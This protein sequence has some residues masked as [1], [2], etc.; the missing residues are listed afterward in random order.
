MQLQFSR[1][2]SL[3]FYIEAF[4]LNIKKSKWLRVFFSPL[5]FLC[6][7]FYFLG[8]KAH[9]YMYKLH[10][11]Q[12]I[13]IPSYVIGIGN[14][15]VGGSGKTPFILKILKDLSQLNPAIIMRPYQSNNFGDEPQLVK[16]KF[17]NA[18]LFIGKSKSDVALGIDEKVHPLAI[19]DDALQHYRLK[20]DFQV[21]MVTPET[22]KEHFLIPLGRLRQSAEN[23]KK[24]NL[25]VVHHVKNEAEF[26]KISS[27]MQ[28]Y[29]ECGIVGTR[30]SF[31]HASMEQIEKQKVAV[32]CGIGSPGPFL[33]QIKK[34]AQVID[35]LIAPDHT[36]HSEKTMIAFANK[37]KKMGAKSLV[38]TEKDRVK[39]S[40]DDR[41][42][43]PI[44]TMNAELE[45]LFNRKEYD[46]F[47]SSIKR[48]TRKV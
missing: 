1:T 28:K 46:E 11:K 8:D 16:N 42:S 4:Y 21:I 12:V 41:L 6:S 36:I 33:E 48:K 20:K 14:I 7:V 17:P 34:Y 26:Q 22:L 15:A 35:T 24:A 32:F 5:F 31:S 43:L 10:L 47:I 2:K 45:I 27:K 37:A 38:C 13:E 23:L 19:V 25:V 29:I 40:F 3:F 44:V 30:M 18:A 9:E 39:I